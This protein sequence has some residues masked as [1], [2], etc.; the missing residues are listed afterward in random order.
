MGR[1]KARLP[2][3]GDLLVSA[4]GGAVS[5]AAGN[6]TLVG[7]P[8]LPGIPDRYPGGGPLG[9]ILT[10]LY[11]SSADWNLI[12]AC[13]MPEVSA[14]FLG[15]LLAHAMRSR[16]GVLLPY[17]PDGLPQPLCAVYHRSARGGLDDHFGRGVRRVTEAL[18][19]LEVEPFFV[20][21]LTPFQN[22]NTPQDWDAYAAK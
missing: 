16:A 22:V 15:E 5:L 17:G 19:G 3:R 14:V 1:D 6:V 12:G 4:V 8:E 11:H 21:E 10:A 2:F 20:A 18:S 13:D 9:G 7:H